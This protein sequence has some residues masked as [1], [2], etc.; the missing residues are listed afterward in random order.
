MK[1]KIT[2]LDQLLKVQWKK[3]TDMPDSLQS[4]YYN[5]INKRNTPRD[6]T[7]DKLCKFFEITE[8]EL[9]KLIK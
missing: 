8:E 3:V 7:L 1:I 2:T 6:T 5:V 4:T 9:L